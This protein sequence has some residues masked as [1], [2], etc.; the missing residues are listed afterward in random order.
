[1]DEMLARTEVP[2][3]YVVG[4]DGLEPQYP[5]KEAVECFTG[6]LADTLE[7]YA[8]LFSHIFDTNA[9]GFCVTIAISKH[10]EPN[11]PRLPC[12]GPMSFHLEDA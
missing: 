6:E 10:T 12:L 5:W 3:H 11:D 4:G 8:P 1:M 7:S 2:V 9:V